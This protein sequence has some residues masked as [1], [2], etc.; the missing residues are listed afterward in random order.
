[1]NHL[2]GLDA[3]FLHV[4]SPEMPMHIGALNVL[5]LPPAYAGE[6]YEDAKA[7]IG[8]RMHLGQRRSSLNDGLRKH[9]LKRTGNL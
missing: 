9:A 7:F 4:E 2:S 8:Q 6:F 5:D 3:M 1:M